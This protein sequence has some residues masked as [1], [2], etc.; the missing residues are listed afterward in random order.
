MEFID[1]PFTYEFIGKV[2]LERH[3]KK[4]H[5]S[6]VET[7]KDRKFTWEQA[8]NYCR[9]FCMD[10][11]SIQSAAEYKTVKD[12]LRQCESFYMDFVHS[13]GWFLGLLSNPN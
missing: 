9:R 2:H 6:W 12:T 1:T 10:A 7:G 11:I 4:Y 3:G 8:R 13:L 5:F